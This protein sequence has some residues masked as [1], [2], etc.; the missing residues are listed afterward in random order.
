M[1]KRILK[2]ER[3]KTIL[4]VPY[5]LGSR[6]PGARFAPKE[7]LKFI[8]NTTA[9]GGFSGIRY[10]KEAKLTPGQWMRTVKRISYDIINRGYLLLS[11][12][13]DHSISYPIILS[14]L[15]RW[16]D[17][18]IIYLDA[19]SDMMASRGL[20]NWNHFLR[21][22]NNNCAQFINIGIRYDPKTLRQCG[23]KSFSKQSFTSAKRS[24]TLA[25][26]S[27]IAG[28]RP[29]YLSIDLDVLDPKYS[30]G[31][32]S[33]FKGGLSKTQLNKI[34]QTLL[35]LNVVACDIVE[36]NP[37]NDQDGKTLKAAASLLQIFGSSKWT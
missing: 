25:K 31:V 32:S 20:R 7:M 6:V 30:P 27:R 37:A 23:V 14:C 26:I 24:R 21:L 17:M 11:L 8:E 29:V 13:G 4:S 33:P 3:A 36:F 9:R 19:H 22:H 34:L 10:I 12:G 18:M 5:D 15:K 35:N 2:N 28:R 1:V 16:K